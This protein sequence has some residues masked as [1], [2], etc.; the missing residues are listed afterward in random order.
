MRL[1]NH[2]L[3][4][5]EL[6]EPYSYEIRTAIP[7]DA[8]GIIECMQ[9]VMSEKIYLVSEV[10]LYT[11][12]GQK[13][14]LR[15][16]DDLNL[17]T[18]FRREVVGTMNIQRG[19]YR[20]NRHTANLGIAIKKEH[21]GKGFG[22]EMINRGIRW[23]REEGIVKLNLEVF[24]SNEDAI[25]LYE[26]LGFKIE[27]SRKGQFLVDEKYVDDVMMTVFPMEH[28]DDVGKTNLSHGMDH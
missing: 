6:M 5:S 23:C 15:N 25:R 22:S 26:K 2:F 11:E 24:S 10:Y 16:P 27:G 13:E 17:V 20:K 19:I 12:R 8:S 28:L 21:R 3:E 1:T 14:I 18:V 9:S 7:S 4:E